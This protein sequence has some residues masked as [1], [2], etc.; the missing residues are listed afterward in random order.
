MSKKIGNTTVSKEVYDGL[1][2]FEDVFADYVKSEEYKELER[3]E[4]ERT[5]VGEQYELQHFLEEENARLSALEI[6]LTKKIALKMNFSQTEKL[7]LLQMERKRVLKEKLALEFIKLD[8]AVQKNIA[9][10]MNSHF[11]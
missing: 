3:K 2:G 5:K 6:F 4:R 7:I 10:L 8:S 11:A 9:H 1:K